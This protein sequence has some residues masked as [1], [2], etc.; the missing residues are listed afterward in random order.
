MQARALMSGVVAYNLAILQQSIAMLDWCISMPDA[1]RF[2]EAIGPHLRH[3]LEHYE[4]L[5]DGLGRRVLEYD[6]RRRDR[7]VE[8]DPRIALDRFAAACRQLRELAGKPMPENVAVMLCGGIDG[9]ENFVTLSTPARELMFLASHAV[10]H[11]AIIKP[12]LVE[13]GYAVGA[14]FGKAPATIHYERESAR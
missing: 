2:P 3:V 13:R 11:Y 4:E 7:S 6:S 14:D 10:H 1:A 8:A 5:L 9:G 12:V